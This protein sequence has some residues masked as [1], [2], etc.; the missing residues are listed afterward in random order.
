LGLHTS[1]KGMVGEL[2][3]VA[4][5]ERNKAPTRDGLPVKKNG[6]DN[7]NKRYRGALYRRAPRRLEGVVGRWCMGKTRGTAGS[8]Q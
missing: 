1:E 2:S 4:V 6:G 7:V 5:L 8:A 3:T